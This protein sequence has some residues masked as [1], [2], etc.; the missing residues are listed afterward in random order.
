MQEIR[1][2][3]V[4]GSSGHDGCPALY[5]VEGLPAEVA[6]GREWAVIQGKRLDGEQ[7]RAQLVDLRDNEDYVMVPKEL[8]RDN[9]GLFARGE[10]KG[11]E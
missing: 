7:V 3:Y 9:M 2:T 5:D 8:I 10:S 4:G 6:D 1:L 11:D